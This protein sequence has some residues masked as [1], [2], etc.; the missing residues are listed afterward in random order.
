MDDLIPG[1]TTVSET[2]V[3][4]EKTI[5]VFND[6]VFTIHKGH[7]N[8]PE[9][10][11]KNEPQSESTNLTYAMGQ[12]GG[13]EQPN[14]KL[15]GVA[16]DRFQDT[17]SVTLTPDPASGPATKRV[18]LSKL[19]RIYDPLGLASPITLA[20][21]LVYRSACDSKIAWDTKLS[22]PFQDGRNGTER[23]RLIPS[24]DP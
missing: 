5:E 7:S 24:L 1:G 3:Q 4:K 12:L 20:R 17:I 15:L 18:I 13:N 8:A 23:L 22:K 10:E 19:V 9:L 16:W 11:P 21:K 6:A 14:G 2:Q